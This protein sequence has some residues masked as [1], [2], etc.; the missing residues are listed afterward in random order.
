MYVFYLR[1]C[2]RPNLASKQGG[3]KGG[4]YDKDGRWKLRVPA[5]VR[6]TKES[7]VFTEGLAA[8]YSELIVTVE[9]D[10]ALDVGTANVV[11]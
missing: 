2:S 6:V 3:T 10:K 11:G 7:G 5:K 4:R 8:S 1:Y 9:K